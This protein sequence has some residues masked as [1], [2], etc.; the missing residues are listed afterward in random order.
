MKR[1]NPKG[2]VLVYILL[3][4]D[5]YLYRLTYILLIPLI[6]FGIIKFFQKFV[7]NPQVQASNLFQKLRCLKC[8]KKIRHGDTYCP[9]CGYYQYIECENWHNLTYK[10]SCY[11]KY[12]RYPQNLENIKKNHFRY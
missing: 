5:V 8:A 3:H 7:F 9:H 1:S 6:G 10:Y 4:S 2:F 11:C 12:C